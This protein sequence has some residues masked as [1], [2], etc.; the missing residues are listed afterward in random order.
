M[1]TD[2][3]YQGFMD[4]LSADQRLQNRLNLPE[5]EVNF[6][7]SYQRSSRPALWFTP[8]RRPVVDKMWM[9]W[10]PDLG[11]PHPLDT[12]NGPT[13]I[14]PADPAGCEYLVRGEDGRQQRCNEPAVCRESRQM[15]KLGLRYCEMRWC[16]FHGRD[17]Q[18]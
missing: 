2:H 4:K 13:P 8:G 14:A 6:L 1:I 3:Q 15:G 16:C 18:A 9:K 17:F 11:Y 12:I 7:A 5:W 10:G